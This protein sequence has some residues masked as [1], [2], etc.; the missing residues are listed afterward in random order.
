[1]KTEVPIQWGQNKRRWHLDRTV[2][3]SHVISFMVVAA[4][5][6]SGY[7]ALQHRAEDNMKRIAGLEQTLSEQQAML[8]KRRL[9]SKSDI[10]RINDKLD[11]IIESTK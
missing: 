3:I 8:E 11:R 7:Q 1:M 2:S 6:L 9:E 4:G 5:I 10:N